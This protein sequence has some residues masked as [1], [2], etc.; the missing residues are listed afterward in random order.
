V[1]AAKVLESARKEWSKYL[2]EGGIHR[3]RALNLYHRFLNQAWKLEDWGNYARALKELSVI[4]L[5]YDI[6]EKIYQAK[7]MLEE[8]ASLLYEKG[9]LREALMV[10]I[11][12][13]PAL[14]LLAELEPL[15][16][17]TILKDGLATVNNLLEMPEIENG[18]RPWLKFYEGRFYEEI[19]HW[20]REM[21]LNF[22][23]KAYS[24]FL[25]AEKWPEVDLVRFARFQRA[26]MQ[27]EDKEYDSAE[28]LLKECLSLAE[29]SGCERDIGEISQLLASICEKKGD[30][31]GANY[32]LKQT[33]NCWQKFGRIVPRKRIDLNL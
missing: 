9:L 6:P 23:K 4:L 12:I 10:Q 5:S 27:I 32:F 14:L 7:R 8:G 26:L 21:R 28:S 20:D 19:A 17:T 31:K 3:R 13:F 33:I 30:F 1:D 22:R 11:A 24:C 18:D 15:K 2:K 16:T 25:E 29:S